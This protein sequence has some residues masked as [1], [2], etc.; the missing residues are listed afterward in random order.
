M[1]SSNF[2]GRP[3]G[4][5]NSLD[6]RA[7]KVTRAN[8]RISHRPLPVIPLRMI[9]KARKATIK[10]SAKPITA[11]PMR[12]IAKPNGPL[13]LI[14]NEERKLSKLKLRSTSAVDILRRLDLG[15]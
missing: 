14:K 8:L 5:P 3:I 2:H 13:E 10:I 9:E 6:V 1:A 7:S 12:T 4:I 15:R 11:I